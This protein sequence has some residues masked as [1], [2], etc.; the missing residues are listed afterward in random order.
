MKYQKPDLTTAA[1]L[2]S[3]QHGTDKTSGDYIDANQAEYNATR[4]AYEADE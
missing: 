1:A 4:P 3:I 2:E